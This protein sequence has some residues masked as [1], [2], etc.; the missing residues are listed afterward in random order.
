MLFLNI[1]FFNQ[2]LE[3]SPDDNEFSQQ[4]L[5]PCAEVLYSQ[6]PTVSFLKTLKSSNRNKDETLNQSQQS[7][8]SANA[9]NNEFFNYS[10]SPNDDYKYIIFF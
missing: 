1:K 5:E 3:G 7:D 6:I 10:D 9:G 2:I 8:V 4:I